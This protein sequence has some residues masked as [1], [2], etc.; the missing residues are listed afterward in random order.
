MRKSLENGYSQ[1][2]A[3]YT[4]EIPGT[5]SGA[6]AT[7]NNSARFTG[8]DLVIVC[9]NN[10]F[11]YSFA[12]SD[13][14]GDQLSYH[15]C[16]AYRS[17]NAGQVNAPLPPPFDFVPYGQGYGESAPLGPNVVV[18][19]QS[20]LITGTAPSSGVYVVTVCVEERGRALTS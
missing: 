15:F 2:G 8:S 10:S 4:C 17:T 16:G 19:Q 9:A 7:V 12:A 13:P 14:D 6:G 20:G 11:S 18:N 3:T 1:I 5:S